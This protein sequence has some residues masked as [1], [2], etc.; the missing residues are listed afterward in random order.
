MLFTLASLPE[1]R[2]DPVA[3]RHF[4]HVVHSDRAA[5]DKELSLR[6]SEVHG[7][8]AALQQAPREQPARNVG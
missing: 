6:H 1:A 2:Q 4:N 7:D 3:D 8:A 5:I